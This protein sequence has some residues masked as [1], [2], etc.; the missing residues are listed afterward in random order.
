MSARADSRLPERL[1]AVRPRRAYVVCATPRSGSTLLCELLVDAGIAGRPAEHVEQLRL[2]GRPIEPREYFADAEDRSMLDLLP[3]SAPPR[4]HGGPIEER[5][6]ATIA[7]A[8]TPNGVFGTKVMWA[9]MADLQERLAELPDFGALGDAE[10]LA[11][12]LG[13]VRF[14]HVHREDHVAQ[15]ISMWRAVQT[16]AWRA[17]TDDA[18]EPVYSF[19]AIEH[20]AH[21]LERHAAAWERWF[22]HQGVSPLRIGYGELAEAPGAALH[23]TLE[24]IG[25]DDALAGEPPAPSMRRQAG[26]PSREWADRYLREEEAHR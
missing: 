18:C 21:R 20:L 8:S 14:V 13:D 16:R 7:A 9:Y 24:L 4:P 17:E 6:A 25:V 11:R 5:L 23:R 22:E 15:A 2:A 3:A 10:R 1:R 12:L 26:E 19:A